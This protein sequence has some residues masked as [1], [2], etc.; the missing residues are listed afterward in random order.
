MLIVVT[1]AILAQAR[2]FKMA[3][4]ENCGRPEKRKAVEEFT[5]VIGN[6]DVAGIFFVLFG[7]IIDLEVNYG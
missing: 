3:R 1:V 2:A 4:V 7:Y 5:N 6:V